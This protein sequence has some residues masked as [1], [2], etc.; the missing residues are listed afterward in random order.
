MRNYQ[1]YIPKGIGGVM[2]TLGFIMLSSPT[3]A[4]RTGHFPEQNVET[5]FYSLNEGLKRLRPKLG[6]ELYQRVMEMSGRM[7]AY[8]EA[9]PN[10]KTGD[11]DKGRRLILEME[12]LLKARARKS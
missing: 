6:D 3:F 1:P 11:A 8:F 9:D 7:R 12:D 4:D 5:T 10:D 2:D